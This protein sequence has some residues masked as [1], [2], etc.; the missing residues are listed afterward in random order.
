MFML[1]LRFTCL[2]PRHPLEELSRRKFV[3]KDGLCHL[4]VSFD[5]L[6]LTKAQMSR[7]VRSLEDVHIPV[8]L[9]WSHPDPSIC[10]SSIAKHLC[11]SGLQVINACK[12]CSELS[13]NTF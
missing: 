5:N 8:I 7:M 4:E 12:L 2:Y 11:D 3:S 9:T 1:Y 6:D 13:A 10:P